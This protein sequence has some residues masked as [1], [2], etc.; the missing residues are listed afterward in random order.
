MIS[1]GDRETVQAAMPGRPSGEQIMNAA[2]EPAGGKGTY[3]LVVPWDLTHPGGVN[4]VVINLYREIERRGP[5]KPLILVLD[6]HSATPR[7]EMSAGC[8]TVRLR[9]R[10]PAGSGLS[11]AVW[12][13]MYFGC[14]RP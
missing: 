5:L 14:R 4:Q 13:D 3:L 9:V 7:E 11:C 8:R 6:W 12:R 1:F 10:Q 2:T